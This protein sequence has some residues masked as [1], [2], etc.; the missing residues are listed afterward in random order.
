NPYRHQHVHAGFLLLNRIDGTSSPVWA[1]EWDPTFCIVQAA[2]L[3]TE[4]CH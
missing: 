1:T 4:D 2:I 3:L